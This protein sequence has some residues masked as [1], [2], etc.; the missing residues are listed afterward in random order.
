M[1]KPGS[2]I[3]GKVLCSALSAAMVVAFA[4]AVGAAVGVDD[5]TTAYAD[6][7]SINAA[8]QTVDVTSSTS[9]A[10]AVSQVAK[11]GTV[12]LTTDVSLVQT[13]GAASAVTVTID[14]DLTLDLNGHNIVAQDNRA[15]HI[16]AGNVTITG[17]GTI[18][19]NIK[20]Q[21][22]NFN[23]E[24]SVIRVGNG[25]EDTTK[26]ATDPSRTN[27]SLKI[28]KNVTVTSD[29]CYGVSAFG[30]T[31][32][33]LEILGT[34]AV[35]GQWCALGGNGTKGF[36][37]TYITLGDGSKLSCTTAPV[38][39]QPQA[40]NLYLGS[41]NIS[42]P[43][44]IEM[45]SGNLSVLPGATPEIKV[46]PPD[47]I[48]ES[49]GNGP[50]TKGGYAVAIVENN[51]YVHGGVP[52]AYL[53]AGTYTGGVEKLQDSPAYSDTSNQTVL[54]ITGGSY[55]EDPTKYV[56]N[57]SDYT[58]TQS[59][60]RYTV[61][62]N[63]QTDKV[64]QVSCSD[65][66]VVL[67][68]DLV[69]AFKTANAT[70]I[71]LLKDVTDLKTTVE[72]PGGSNITLDL[73]GK[74]ISGTIP[75]QQGA[76]GQMHA[77]S[78][79]I[80]VMYSS[81]AGGANLTVTGNGKITNTGAGDRA[82]VFAVSNNANL[83]IENGTYTTGGYALLDCYGTATIKDGSFTANYINT[84][85]LA[86]AIYAIG[87]S[88]KL[89]FE[90]G[91][92]TAPNCYGIYAQNGG[93]NVTL[94]T[95]DGNGPSVTSAWSAIGTDNASSAY[96]ITVNGG[97]YTAGNAST[98]TSAQANA[99]SV[100]CL[101]APGTVNLKAATF[102]TA[103]AATAAI[104]IPYRNTGLNLNISGGT[105]DAASGDAVIRTPQDTASTGTSNTLQVT[106]GTFNGKLANLASDNSYRAFLTGGT[107]SQQ[108]ADAYLASGYSAQYINGA[109]TV[110][111]SSHVH[112]Y[113][114]VV[115]KA[116]TCTQAGVKTFTCEG[117][118]N[119]SSSKGCGTTYTEPIAALGHSFKTGTITWTD[120]G[121]SAATAKFTCANDS[122]HTETVTAAI[123]KTLTVKPTCTVKGT[124]TYTAT[125]TS[126]TGATISA[127]KTAQDEPAL[128]HSYG[129]YTITTA[130]TTTT[131]GV[132]VAKCTHEDCTST[133]TSTVAK[134]EST[135]TA[136][137]GTASVEVK[138][139]DAKPVTT[140]DG[141]NAVGSVT[142]TKIPAAA[143]AIDIP[144]TVTI[145]G[146]QY[147]VAG[148]E[149]AAFVGN[150]AITSV[151][152]P[153]TVTSIPEG[154]FDGCSSLVSVTLPGNLTQIPGYAFRNTAI[155]S[156]KIP[157][158]VTSI[159]ANAFTNSSLV[160]IELPAAVTSVGNNAF[161][162]CSKLTLVTLPANLQAVPKG[163]FNGCSSL[164][165]V[166]AAAS[167]SA[168]AANLSKATKVGNYA[169]KGCKSLV[170][171][172]IRA[173]KTIGVQAF[174]NCTKLVQVNAAKATAVKAN[175]FK[176]CSRLATLKIAKVK[177]IGANAFAGAKKLKTLTTG[178]ALTSIGSKAFKGASKLKT[179]NISSKR[180][181]ESDVTGSL[182]G[183]AV[184]TVKVKV[185]GSKRTKALY[186]ALY[187]EVFA[188]YNSGKKV[189]VK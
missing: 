168:A 92:L 140:P 41:T 83:T 56:G 64:A 13:S 177:T 10:D 97:V 161:K 38:I 45:K 98:S 59:G 51:S 73:N 12:R 5:A 50:S 67:A 110:S 132:A 136:T 180:L 118:P 175:A 65:G 147:A 47:K 57:S 163:L 128:G 176:N 77:G 91:T 111:K 49:F 37:A 156:I 138:V 75:A 58:V 28:D 134:L 48:H 63:P 46:T 172:D 81:S 171:V 33:T 184:T 11:G 30:A 137:A 54:A 127:S 143:T 80:G 131:T 114:M 119:D 126:S 78:P 87:S 167:T 145:D 174:A 22:L 53:T 152:L 8:P 25:S 61:A 170:S 43:C 94:G 55:S 76:D 79:L 62:L 182:K 90:K 169:F 186:A 135:Q 40:G 181:T 116:A 6:D 151:S 66:S 9:L 107:F 89:D 16:T 158:T 102:K 117:D 70:T 74:S 146:A 72:V 104:C 95:A 185:S 125:A 189:I 24:S 1:K 100:V 115:T 84:S 42:G 153:D 142:I 23:S 18:S 27:V 130:P 7:A 39:Y 120:N 179:L 32:E 101:Q 123:S 17:T 60:S 52:K 82:P 68:A 165:A 19:A 85:S 2:S 133:I 150:T 149:K 105:F 162:G 129:A 34:I 96:N 122:S 21:S 20:D 141:T 154:L 36:G 4:P 99:N 106:G 35:T 159:G 124:N 112:K 139:N 121:T 144:Q 113:T 44:G 109:Y 183:S 164:V 160:S 148:V 71:K 69:S 3:A 166:N 26:S 178:T 187:A 29:H 86:S 31:T 88:A 157:S 188:K 103:N 173:A 15:L 93:G 14:K 108:P 155:T